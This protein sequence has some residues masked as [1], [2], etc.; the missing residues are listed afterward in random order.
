LKGATAQTGATNQNFTPPVTGSYKV[1]ITD[2]I[3]CS[4]TSSLLAV[5]LNAAPTPSITGASSIC[6]GS[7]A[8][9]SANTTYNSY[10]WSTGA[11]TQSISVSQAGT[12]SL[13]VT[14]GGACT[15]SASK[16]LSVTTPPTASITVSG[17][18]QFC[19]GGSVILTA[20][21]VSSSYLWSDGKI[22]QTNTAIGSGVFTV[23]VTDANGCTGISTATTV[24]EWAV[25]STTITTSGPTSFCSGANACTLS[26]PTGYSYQWKKGTTSL[27]G[28]TN[29]TFVPTST[30]TYKLTTTDTHSCSATSSTGVSITVNSNPTANISSPG[31]MNICNGQTKTLNANINAT[32]T[33]QWK[34]DGSNIA[35]ATGT[36]YTASVA[37]SYTCVE[38][39]SN[40]CS[41]TSNT[42][43]VTANCKE[44]DG[45]SVELPEIS[46][47]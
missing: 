12:Y 24:T 26:G 39:N 19:D 20:N 11:T 40:N 5:T 34:K 46:S 42:L 15:G 13:T 1:K 9:L 7:A 47:V 38:T 6:G 44:S 41:T 17:P 32:V 3:G 29:R 43:V 8:T 37:G 14:N 22:G 28:E 16:T 23:V 45:E 21:P 2:N 30:A 35:G 10:L 31:S 4:A 27:T 36:S 18:T 33:Y 25:P